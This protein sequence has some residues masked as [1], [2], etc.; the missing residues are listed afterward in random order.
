ML[1]FNNF[2]F[3]FERWHWCFLTFPVFE[4]FIINNKNW[5]DFSTLIENS[6]VKYQIFTFTFVRLL[7]ALCLIGLLVAIMSDAVRKSFA[8][9]YNKI[10]KSPFQ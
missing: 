7:M 6:D 5:K 4:Y 9:D 2:E 8:I 1:G 3:E 10:F